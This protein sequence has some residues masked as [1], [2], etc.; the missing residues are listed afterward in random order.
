MSTTNIPAATNWA[1]NPSFETDIAGYDANGFTPART[2]NVAFAGDYSVRM[3]LASVATTP[4][5]RLAAG[6]YWDVAEGDTVNIGLRI[7]P[8]DAPR[9]FFLLVDWYES[10]GTTVV[11]TTETSEAY[12]VATASETAYDWVE[13]RWRGLVVPADAAKLRLTFRW[14]DATEPQ[15]GDKVFI[16]ALMLRRNEALDVYFD[17]D[18]DGCDW[19]GAAHASASTRDADAGVRK[20]DSEA[21]GAFVHFVFL[22]TNRE[23]ERQQDLTPYLID[24]TVEMDVDRDVP[25]TIRFRTRD[26]TLLDPYQDF[27]SIH[28]RVE[29]ADD[30]GPVNKQLGLFT[31][32]VPNADVDWEKSEGDYEGADLTSLLATSAFT[33]AYNIASGTNY[34]TAIK[35]IITGAGF[36]SDRVQ[37]QASS[38]TLPKKKTFPIGTT[39]LEAVNKLL[40]AIAYYPVWAL[41]NGTLTSMHV[42]RRADIEPIDS[43]REWDLLEPV[44]LRP[45]P[46][47]IAN[48]VIV[49]RDSGSQGI[50]S[51]KAI[52]DDPDSPH[53]TVALGR[54]IVRIERNADIDD[55]AAAQALADDLLEEG[56]SYYRSLE[57][58]VSP[59]PR[60]NVHQTCHLR[61]FNEVGVHLSGRYWIRRWQIGFQPGTSRLQ[62][63]IGKVVDLSDE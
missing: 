16:D 55:A 57:I 25:T 39:R 26:T 51:A 41:P 29:Y 13:I 22:R 8:L 50:I 33:T 6:S 61:F 17:G 11:G 20:P 37:I 1:I 59:N 34:V 58:A 2:T 38:K 42:Q 18:S 28:M 62:L 10:D 32:N 54:E 49:I 15:V 35:S 7:Y 63:E 5:L 48:V 12:T 56:G 9:D 47:T 24:G 30:R 53:S 36:E 31:V 3:Q 40:D 27:V 4:Y 14:K 44:K 19:T 52:N 45:V 23:N 43:Y 21:A 60:V 46:D